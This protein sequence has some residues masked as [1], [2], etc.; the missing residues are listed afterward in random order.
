MA[1]SLTKALTAGSS[2]SSNTLFGRTCETSTIVAASRRYGRLCRPPVVVPPMG[3]VY[4]KH[5][6]PHQSRSSYHVLTRPTTALGTTTVQKK[7]EQPMVVANHKRF[8][9]NASKRDF[10]DVLGVGRSADKGE[11]KKAYFALAKKFH[12]DTNRVGTELLC[13]IHRK[14]PIAILDGE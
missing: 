13:F 10:Y 14:K 11:I 2:V 6:Q 7:K 5:H 9:A 1:F 3:N 12:P 4:Q 8:F